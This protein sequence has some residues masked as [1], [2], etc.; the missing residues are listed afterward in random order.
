MKQIG[1]KLKG[2]FLYVNLIEVIEGDLFEF[3]P[4]LENIQMDRNKIARIGLGAFDGLNKLHSIDLGPN[5][6][7]PADK[8][9]GTVKDRTNALQLIQNV[10]TK[11]QLTYKK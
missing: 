4:N 8:N 11:L 6:C 5:P 7:V 10:E 3:N 2:L 1:D 9:D